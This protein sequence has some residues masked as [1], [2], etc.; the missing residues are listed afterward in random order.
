MNCLYCCKKNGQEFVRDIDMALLHRVLCW[1]KTHNANA[2]TLSGGEPAL[3]RDF[4]FILHAVKN[5]KYDNLRVMTNGHLFSLDL[6]AATIE[7]IDEVCFSID[8]NVEDNNLATRKGFN[9]SI[10]R[11]IDGFHKKHPKIVLTIKSTITT[12][13]KDD[14]N[15]LVNFAI[16]YGF[17]KVTFGFC[18]PLGK[19]ANMD[20]Y[21]KIRGTASELFKIQERIIRIKRRYSS[22][23][24][25]VEPCVVFGCKLINGVDELDIHVD[26]NGFIYPCDGMNDSR[27]IVGN[28]KDNDL[29]TCIFNNLENIKTIINT[30]NEKCKLCT[31]AESC[32]GSCLL[33]GN[34]VSEYGADMFCDFRRLKITKDNLMRLISNV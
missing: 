16:R 30:N 11:E 33:Y 27:F 9:E 32:E 15:S 23:I 14:L 26:E 20:T 3:H 7:L 28:I 2:I 1:G 6:D 10:F 19:G 18:L 12:Y 4:D 24:E 5:K 13:N 25:I 17:S 29:E 31:I 8:S 21:N 22:L 34:P